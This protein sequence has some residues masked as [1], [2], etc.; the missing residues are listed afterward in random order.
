MKIIKKLNILIVVCLLLVLSIS[1]SY[2]Y[3]ARALSYGVTLYQSK[4]VNID[5]IGEYKIY[6]SSESIRSYVGY[7][8]NRGAIPT[9]DYSKT[10]SDNGEIYHYADSASGLSNTNGHFFS[11]I[12]VSDNIVTASKNGY[13][14]FEATA[15]F[16]SE[17]YSSFF[18]K[19]DALDK[20]YLSLVYGSSDTV[21]INY[22]EFVVE[23][24]GTSS[25]NGIAVDTYQT[26]NVHLNKIENDTLMLHAY[27]N[28]VNGGSGYNIMYYRYPTIKVTSTDK[29]APSVVVES[30]NTGWS[31]EAK[32]LT[33]TVT[34]AESGI[35]NLTVNGVALKPISITAT[36]Q[37]AVYEY[38]ISTN[39][40]Y[41]ITAV[42]NV[43]NTYTTSHV[44]S[45]ID[46]EIPHATIV[47]NGVTHS[48]EY[49]FYIEES[50]AISPQRFYYTIDGSEPSKES[51]VAENENHVVFDE[52]GKY[53]IKVKGYDEAGNE[54]ET[55]EREV[56]YDDN[57][58]ILTVNVKNGNASE[59]GTYK[60]GDVVVIEHSGD[61]KTQLY[62]ILING[63]IYEEEVVQITIT[64]SVVVDIIYRREVSVWLEK[65]EY[66]FDKIGIIPNYMTD[67]ESVDLFNFQYEKDGA[68]V[69]CYEVGSYLV[70]YNV[71]N[72]DYIGNGTLNFVVLP[73]KVEVAVQSQ[74]EYNE[75]FEFEYDISDEIDYALT[76]TKNGEVVEPLLPSIYE[77]SFSTTDG[78]YELDCT[79]TFEIVKRKAK[80]EI[81]YPTVYGGQ[82][83]QLFVSCDVPVSYTVVLKYEGEIVSEI[84]NAGEYSYCIE[85]EENDLYEGK[86]E[87]VFSVAKRDVIVTVEN[88]NSV[89]G[90]EVCNLTYVVEN[91]VDDISF[92]LVC[93]LENKVGSYPITIEKETYDN[94]NITYVDGLYMIT[95][96]PLSIVVKDG[97][98]KYYGTEDVIEYEIDGLLFDD[99]IEGSLEREQGEDVGFYTITKGT[100]FADNYNITFEGATLSI[101]PS[102]IVIKVDNAEKVY[103]EEDPVFTYKVLYGKLSFNDEVVLSRERGENCGKYTISAT[104]NS[105]YVLIPI[106]GTLV[107]NKGEISVYAKD[108]ETEYGTEVELIYTCDK[109]VDFYGELEREKG[110]DVGDYQIK[111]GSLRCDNYNINFIGATYTIKPKVITVTADDVEVI[112]GSSMPLTYTIAG[113]LV[114][115]CLDGELEREEGENVGEYKILQGSLNHSNYVIEFVGATYKIN[116]APLTVEI[117]SQT[118]IYGDCDDEFKYSV[119]GLIGFDETNVLLEREEGEDV[120]VYQISA[121]SI[122]NA[123]YYVKAQN[124]GK[125]EILKKSI[126]LTLL[127]KTVVYNGEIQS[128]DK[129][130]SD[131]EI[132]YEYFRYG[133][134][135]AEPKD[136]GEYEV[137][138]TFVG[139]E[140][141]HGATAMAKL[142]ILKR[143]V[144]I[145]IEEKTFAYTGIAI[146]PKYVL[147]VDVPVLIE[148]ENVDYAIEVGEYVYT[149]K[150]TEDNYLLEI[151]GVLIIE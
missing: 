2:G 6:S 8:V 107:I 32:K 110:K 39:G 105:N 150:T 81:E 109:D 148:F 74:Y 94:Y 71:D 16:K 113:S 101:L 51:N 84:Y 72:S 60:Y 136:A 36:T 145:V 42:D 149:I 89:Y 66:V 11:Y 104:L 1:V 133:V 53:V 25:N 92:N 63:E 141:Y 45:G 91:L 139:N 70:T 135:V 106:L 14:Q 129:I 142:V 35:M 115:D 117:E 49:A 77:Y 130:E 67:A 123:N 76:F 12:T 108:V 143:I 37:S 68:T 29:T 40:N 137:K 50:N 138:A 93:N 95:P 59:G 65:T 44:E 4:T 3:E 46:M 15:Q 26:V 103:G 30:S 56:V 7:H 114:Y 125:L 31:N 13:A 34:D 102:Q 10:T 146:Y 79:G 21:E 5:A 88:K 99:K 132:E 54:S 24:E 86:A 116:P 47:G 58:Y 140:N 38:E 147:G 78:N 80:F 119:S 22:D 9:N 52:M 90:Q 97:Q 128:I 134:K 131:F 120:G 20:A 61:E 19:K 100:L 23:G 122:D 111:L 43:G 127:D 151:K 124:C 18:I 96:A 33:L 62:S 41:E 121:I 83:V 64:S 48:Q 87:N 85:I 144:P 27:S 118:K 82:S 73:K 57:D 55:I 28:F 126:D 98:Y 75:I 69:L 112:Y 17:I